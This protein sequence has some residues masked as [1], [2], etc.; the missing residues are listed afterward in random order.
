MTIVTKDSVQ[1]RSD[2][3]SA[4]VDE[5]RRYLYNECM[6]QSVSVVAVDCYCHDMFT[7]MNRTSSEYTFLELLHMLDSDTFLVEAFARYR[8]AVE[9]R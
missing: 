3:I 7:C 2:R 5:V 8:S 6:N 4:F 9:I 1:Q